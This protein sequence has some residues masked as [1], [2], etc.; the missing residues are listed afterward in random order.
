MGLFLL[1]VALPVYPAGHFYCT[2]ICE[3]KVSRMED[4]I[5]FREACEK[6]KKETEIL[7]KEN[8]AGMDLVIMA[9]SSSERANLIRVLLDFGLRFGDIKNIIEQL[10]GSKE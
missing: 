10:D 8:E 5:R 1:P 7:R 3:K 6:I 4:E 2:E 9:A